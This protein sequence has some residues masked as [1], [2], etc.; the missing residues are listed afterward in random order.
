MFVLLVSAC[1]PDPAPPARAEARRPT[2]YGQAEGEVTERRLVVGQGWTCALD[3]ERNVRCWGQLP[4]EEEPRPVHEI[5][6][7][8]GAVQIEGTGAGMCVRDGAGFVKT[9][10]EGGIADLDSLRGASS[11]GAG[12]AL[13]C[14]AFED[15]H[16]A[17]AFGGE[18]YE[19]AGQNIDDAIDMRSVGTLACARRRE[20]LVTCWGV[21]EG[22]PFERVQPG[23]MPP[24]RLGTMSGRP[25]LIDDDGRATCITNPARLPVTF[26]VR[27]L[28]G[29]GADYGAIDEGGR[30][31]VFDPAT[32]SFNIHGGDALTVGVSRVDHGCVM[33]VDGAV[34]CWGD[35]RQ[36]QVTGVLPARASEVT[37][38]RG[39]RG[40]TDV[41]LANGQACAL[42]EGALLCWS[43]T[44]AEA[45]PIDVGDVALEEIVHTGQAVC[46]RDA[47]ARV[48]CAIEGHLV[49]IPGIT[50]VSLHEGVRGRLVAVDARGAVVV[51]RADPARAEP[52]TARRLRGA[53]ELGMVD[54]MTVCGLRRG[55][56]VCEV[57]QGGE[58]HEPEITGASRLFVGGGQRFAVSEDGA[59]RAWGGAG[60]G[61]LGVAPGSG[62]DGRH[63][64]PVA[65]EGLPSE[66]LTIVA[67][68]RA[69]CAYG[70]TGPL[71]CAGAVPFTSEGD[72]PGFREVEGVADVRA[73]ALRGGAGCAV[74]ADGEVRCWGEVLRADGR[75][76]RWLTPTP[77]E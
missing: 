27:A 25:C 32:R 71:R 23:P 33:R 76:R 5:E 2:R 42:V 26:P 37:T 60:S 70:A 1:G 72:A 53:T 19:P 63:G 36:G 35:D 4:W 56:L 69:S 46:G 6:A 67:S 65:V 29:W 66:E 17:C 14:A 40:A 61:E 3:E 12:G 10:S 49:L 58:L 22:S 20:N 48:H 44:D 31:H 68:A 7:L 47:E 8:R 39:V 9:V 38:V 55:A 51:F 62:P 57:P 50:A 41:A 13:C 52:W 30:L 77:V 74:V 34:E 24:A 59:V 18:P 75:A 28:E 11:V 15:G 64:E 45:S 54:R 16:V 43:A 73:F 21:R